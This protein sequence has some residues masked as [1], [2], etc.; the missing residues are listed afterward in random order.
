MD[1]EGRGGCYKT[2]KSKIIGGFDEYIQLTFHL[3][4]VFVGLVLSASSPT[5]SANNF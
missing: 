1:N 2:L 3:V 4:S 5:A